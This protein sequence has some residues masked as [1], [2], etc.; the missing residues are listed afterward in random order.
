MAALGP[1]L[2]RRIGESRFRLWFDGKTKIHRQGEQLIVGVPNLFYQE[3]LQNTFSTAVRES[4]QEI[5]GLSLEVRFVIDS[6][7]FRIAR[8]A[9]E[10]A[11]ALLATVT[12]AEALETPE[13]PSV[14]A[15]RPA[16]QREARA[17]VRWRR[18]EDFIAGP[19]T[20]V[21]HS[22]ARSLVEDPE[23]APSPLVFHGPTGVGKT[24][25]LE[26]IAHAFAQGQRDWRVCYLT[27]EEFT[28]RFLG[29]FKQ[30]QVERVSQVL[31]RRRPAVDHDLQFL[32]QRD[33]RRVSAHA[34]CL[35]QQRGLVVISCDCHPR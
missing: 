24:H 4:A 31:P 33:Q 13:V 7:L 26:G 23:Q 19:G 25:L 6:E 14:R 15:T 5:T 12:Q 22:A 30:R 35:D 10:G 34:G 11:K 21:A 1:L 28:N 20:R 3:W 27:A 8:E 18:L 32:A 16:I 2:V 17:S 29:A 9:E